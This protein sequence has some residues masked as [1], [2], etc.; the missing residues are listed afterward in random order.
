MKKTIIYVVRHAESAHNRSGSLSQEPGTLYGTL[1][2][3]LTEVGKQQASLLARELKD[4]PFHCIYA[5]H[6]NRAKQTAEILSEALNLP[7]YMKETL[8]ERLDTE[9]EQEAGIRLFTYVEEIAQLC[10]EQTIL[11]VSHGAI[12][13]GMLM[14]L[15]FAHA[16]ELPPGSVANTGYVV[17]ETDGEQWSITDTRGIVKAL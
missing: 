13:R 7:V 6:L 2:S 12:L 16:L 15:D 5:S 14:I 11:V 3:S 10:R 1:G 17:L 4:L 8:Q 9:S